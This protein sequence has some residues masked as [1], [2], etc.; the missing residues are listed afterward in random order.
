MV[1]TIF[2][3]LGS[4]KEM[5]SSDA[6]PEPQQKTTKWYLDLHGGQ[7]Q[8][9]TNNVV[10]LSPDGDGTV[11][12][13]DNATFPGDFRIMKPRDMLLLEDGR[14]VLTSSEQDHSGL[15]LFGPPNWQGRRA[16]L[17]ALALESRENPLL[18]HPYGMTRGP[19]GSI[20]VSCQ[21]SSTVLRYGNPL[22]TR[23]GEPLT[24]WPKVGPG[25]WIPPHKHHKHG[26]HAPRGIAFGWDGHLYVSDRDKGVS[27]WD[28]EG[29]FV[30]IVADKH[31]GLVKPIQIVFDSRQR[32]FIGDRGAHTVW[33]IEGPD[34][35]P[36]RF[37]P[38]DTHQPKL[39]SALAIDEDWLYVGDRDRREIRR[40]RLSDGT[41]DEKIWLKDLPDSPEFL[42]NIFSMDQDR[43]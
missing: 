9:G 18:S 1:M 11:V 38:E 41:P 13:P 25:C 31:S 10:G 36:R 39:P 2:L 12:I 32:L 3:L 26:L 5:G 21:D 37:I 17:D 28:K 24:A 7:A 23:S 29:R 15:F 19:D 8:P 14:L 40:Y 4:C 22:S 42:L 6:V 34:S 20:Y 43:R 33:I 30:R 27:A 35:K 16:F